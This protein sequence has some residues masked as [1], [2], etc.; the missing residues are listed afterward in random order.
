MTS[1]DC[2][3]RCTSPESNRLSDLVRRTTPEGPL[4]ALDD[5]VEHFLADA[6]PMTPSRWTGLRPLLDL[7]AIGAACGSAVSLQTIDSRE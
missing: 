1:L 6:P 4:M 7:Q 5:A 3:R 2:S